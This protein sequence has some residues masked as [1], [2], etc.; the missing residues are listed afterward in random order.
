MFYIPP[1]IIQPPPPPITGTLLTNPVITGG[2]EGLVISGTQ[3]MTGPLSSMVLT[4]SQVFASYFTAIALSPPAYDLGLWDLL[5]SN[6]FLAQVGP[7]VAT[8]VAFAT[9]NVMKYY[10]AA[11]IGIMA[12]MYIAGFVMKKIGSKIPENSPGA[13]IIREGIEG[14]GR[15]R[16]GL[17]RLPSSGIRI[18]GGR[19]RRRGGW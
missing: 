18:G 7:I 12:F 14:Y 17:P 15:Q 1:F 11:R 2:M 19:R 16:F 4:Q 10:F 5:F 13:I 6:A 3:V 9:P 8:I